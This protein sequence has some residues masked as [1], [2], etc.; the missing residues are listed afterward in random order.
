MLKT[1]LQGRFRCETI[2]DTYLAFLIWLSDDV[3]SLA[4]I[5][6]Y[7]LPIVVIGVKAE[8]LLS[9]YRFNVGIIE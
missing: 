6:L 1:K 8:P 2:F 5:S 7:P 4:L 9:L 3:M